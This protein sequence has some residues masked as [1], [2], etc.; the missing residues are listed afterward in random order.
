M[1]QSIRSTG[2]VDGDVDISRTRINEEQITHA[3]KCYDYICI[4][5]SSRYNQISC[6]MDYERDIFLQLVDYLNMLVG[7]LPH[8]HA[9]YVPI[10]MCT[11]MQ[12]GIFK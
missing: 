2:S 1:W 7:S 11:E 4:V 5:V 12:N 8:N 6:G 9:T 10:L 3:G